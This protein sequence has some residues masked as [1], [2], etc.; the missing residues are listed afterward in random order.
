MGA[1]I[2]TPA[3]PDAV[4]MR[5]MLPLAAAIAALGGL[6]FG[7]DLAVI[8]GAILF[9]RVEFALTP[10]LTEVTVAASLLGAMLGATA[11][12]R[13]ADCWG[14]RRPLFLIAVLGILGPLCTSLAPNTAWLILG[15]VLTGACF[16]MAS[17][18]APLYIAE[19]SPSQSRGR[20]VSIY[21]LAVMVGMMISYLIDYAFSTR[22]LWR[23]MFALGSIPAFILGIGSIFLPESPRWLMLHGLSDKACDTLRQL[24]GCSDVTEEVQ[25]I[26]KSLGQSLGSWTELWHP[27]LHIALIIGAGLAFF[28][29][30]TGL[31]T[32]VF[33]A[34][35]IFELAGFASQS[36]DIFATLSIGVAMVLAT[37]VALYL[38]DH[39][40]RRTLL[41][42]GLAGMVVSLFG[43][44]L[45]FLPQ[46]QGVRG[47][48]AILSLIV[49]SA[50][51]VIGP[52]T[53][54]YLLVSEIY[55]LHIRGLAMSLV[56]AIL[57][58]A[59]LIDT[60]TFLS[61]LNF[62]GRTTTFWFNA[63]LGIVAWGFV[64]FLVP[65][66]KGLSLEEIEAHWR[67]QKPPRELGK[68]P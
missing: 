54:F 29:Q 9:I 44:G 50:A 25:C 17:F 52:G 5:S 19:L 38:V 13:I 63:F 45:A 64:Y 46:F 47:T 51:W 67:C 66:T 12:G 7:Y 6:V 35:T 1:T 14:R 65:E 55:P 57:W 36:A 39:W 8:A 2:P 40:G 22:H 18:V 49:F 56:T 16:G 11:G 41:L 26:F 58:G 34:P 62:L 28:R 15:R 32:A 53:I 4:R 30:V 59:Y 61:L 42:S 20:M 27:Y 60:L 21:T 37:L 24:R 33:Y 68:N 43:L 31:T 48:I 23:Y 3:S 10:V